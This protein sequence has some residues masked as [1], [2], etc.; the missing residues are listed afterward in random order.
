MPIHR[1]G[2]PFIAIAWPFDGPGFM[3][4]ALFGAFASAVIGFVLWLRARVP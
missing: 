2:W 1:E 4:V 3:P